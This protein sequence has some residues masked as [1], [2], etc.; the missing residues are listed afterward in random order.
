MIWPNVAD[1]ILRQSSLFW[2]VLMLLDPLAATAAVTR[3]QIFRLCVAVQS[4]C[5]LSQCL[6]KSV[7]IT[8]P[9]CSAAETRA[10]VQHSVWTLHQGHTRLQDP[11]PY[12]VNFA[13]RQITRRRRRRCQCAEH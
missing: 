1:F 6:S 5:F 13:H 12:T 4:D 11:D 9:L 7:Q 10:K 8:H 2:E 3:Q